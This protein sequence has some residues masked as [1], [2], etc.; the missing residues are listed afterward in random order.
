MSLVHPAW[1]SSI[2]AGMLAVTLQAVTP[3]DQASGQDAAV[4][5]E[6]TATVGRWPLDGP[7]SDP[8]TFLADWSGNGHDLTITGPYGW[9]RDRGFSRDGALRLELADDSCAEAAGP[10]LRTDTSFTVAAWVLLEATTGQHVIVSQAAKTR[11]G[12]HLEYHPDADRWQFGLPSRGKGGFARWHTVTSQQPPELG[13]W[14]HL[15]GVY[16]VPAGKVRLYV[17]G[18]LQGEAAGPQTPW[19]ADGPTLIGCTG[20][21]QGHRSSPLGGAIDDV[22]LWAFTVHPDRIR[23]LAAG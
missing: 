22:R 14:T 1:L 10:V 20:T 21:T 8:P 5:D 3:S 6:L 23:G 19:M 2:V 16:D 12:F 11:G 17:D 9:S 7:A 18:V 4:D 15:A 13:R